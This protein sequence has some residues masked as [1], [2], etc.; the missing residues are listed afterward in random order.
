[1]Y[2]PFAAFPPPNSHG[3]E[4]EQKPSVAGAQ[5]PTVSSPIRGRHERREV[6]RVAGVTPAGLRPAPAGG[7]GREAP[8]PQATEAKR[9]L[10]ARDGEAGVPVGRRG[11]CFMSATDQ[12]DGNLAV[13]MADSLTL[14]AY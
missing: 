3:G 6:F 14:W 9:S 7:K 13:N 10:K 5:R 2:S 1:M 11:D 8:S 12:T 4:C